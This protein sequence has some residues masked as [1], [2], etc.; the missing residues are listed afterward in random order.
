MV[1]P[2]VTTPPVCQ[3]CGAP[4]RPDGRFC[5]RCGGRLGEG[6]G[7]P[8]LGEVLLGRYRVTRVLG[9]GTMGRVYL[10]EQ[11][12]GE[13]VRN[14]AIK[15][16]AA[17]RGN[18]DYIVARFRREATTVASLEHPNIIRLYDYGEEGGRFLSVMEYVPGG[19]LASLLARGRL[20]P[21]RVET[22]VWQ[23]AAALDAAHRKGI[24]HRDLKPENVLMA[25]TLDGVGALDV[26]KVVD[27]G[28]ARRPPVTVGERPLTITG[29]MLGT[30][31]YMSPE[32]FM[33]E[34][35]D[36]RADVYGLALVTYQMLAGAL[37]WDASSVME[38]GEAQMH[39]APRPLRSQPGCEGL[40]ERYDVALAR[41]LVKDARRR[42]ATTLEFARD[43]SGRAE[44]GAAPGTAAGPAVRGAAPAAGDEAG[45]APIV[46]SSRGPL[47]VGAVLA[48]LALAA[49]AALV[50]R[51]VRSPDEAV[52]AD[53]AAPVDGALALVAAGPDGGARDAGRD[54]PRRD[55]TSTDGSGPRAPTG[56]TRTSSHP[57]RHAAQRI[58]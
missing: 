58:H 53:A 52:T 5:Q 29:A 3:R 27:F 46:R 30:P 6:A 10:G 33:G 13:S 39:K 36:A 44:P 1:P 8:L 20:A 35:V 31:A 32:Q 34:A 51:A 18:D 25:S 40:P 38:W 28:I 17:S 26:V 2:A 22:I 12:V 7:D 49:G 15:A 37:P 55:G 45:L 24:V 23:M 43:L 41:A 57:S 14:V 42:T 11:R 50:I 9:E 56:R 48:A 21:E 16:L 4:Q 19:S 47:V 54:A